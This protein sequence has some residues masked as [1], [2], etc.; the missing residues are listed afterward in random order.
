MRVIRKKSVVRF[1]CTASQLALSNFQNPG[2]R[3]SRLA[4]SAR[5]TCNSAACSDHV[6]NAVAV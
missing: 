4:L 3:R 1:F 5:N 6:C 2:P